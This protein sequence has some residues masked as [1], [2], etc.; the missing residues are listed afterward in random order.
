VIKEKTDDW[1][2]L[3]LFFSFFIIG[4]LDRQLVFFFFLLINGP[5]ITKDEERIKEE[6]KAAM[7]GRTVGL[8]SSMFQPAVL[9]FPAGIRRD[10]PRPTFH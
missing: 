9:Y 4:W 3:L 6:K 1:S 7:K 10:D 2:E 5:A 8:V